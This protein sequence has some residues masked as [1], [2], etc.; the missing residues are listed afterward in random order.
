MRHY[1]KLVLKHLLY[2]IYCYFAWMLPY[3][4]HPEKYPFAKKYD[5]FRKFS[6]RLL[7]SFSIDLKIEGL[8][9]VPKD[10]VCYFVCNHQSAIDPLFIIQALDI[11]ASVVAKKE[12]RKMP[13]IGKA[14]VALDGIFLDRENLKQSL[15]V[16][17]EL[18]E[19]LIE[20]NKNWFI[21]PEGT[22]I[23]DPLKNLQP[24]HPGAFR[25]PMKANVPIIPCALYGA[26][27][28]LKLKPYLKRYPV[29]LKFL[30]PIYPEQYKDMFT[31]DVAKIT[32][33]IIENEIAYNLRPKHH[34]EMLK[35]KNKKYRATEAI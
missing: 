24:F 33:D 1:I 18:Q 3:S 12:T 31:G 32:H 5:K 11:P 27:R 30:P 28:V 10:Q 20:R 16:M 21:F 13:L 7:S 25:A 29:T 15:K 2:T 4:R 14:L 35:L 17:L 19:D 22:R 8:E 9:N 23:K 34:E 6:I 26:F